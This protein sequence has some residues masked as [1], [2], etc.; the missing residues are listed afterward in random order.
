MYTSSPRPLV[1]K[2]P[3]YKYKNYVFNY[4]RCEITYLDYNVNIDLAYLK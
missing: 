3:N 2:T 1:K 4:L